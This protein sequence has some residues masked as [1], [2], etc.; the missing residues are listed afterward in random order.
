[1]L[2][3]IEIA[4]SFQRLMEECELTQEG[5][6]QKVGKNR[7]TVTNYLRLLK[8]PADVQIAIRD[9]KISMGHARAVAG[10]EN[11]LDQLEV[12]KKILKDGLSVRQTEKLA[13]LTGEDKK[14]KKAESK[15]DAVSLSFEQQK[16]KDDLEEYLG[17]RISIKKGNNGVG[18]IV[19]NFAS[20]SDFKRIIDLLDF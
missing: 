20:E 8:L 1:D 19:I 6:S 15:D 7:S 18:K 11:E 17:T 4:I 12:L 10:I 13:S 2:D 14:P 3:A 5:L 9:K 16:V